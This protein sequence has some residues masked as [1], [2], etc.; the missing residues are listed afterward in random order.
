VEGRP[1]P[2][3]PI[4]RDEVYRISAE[5]LRN[6]FRHSQSRQ[7]VLEIRYDN[8]LLR[9]RIRDD[10]TGIDPNV[11]AHGGREG[12]FGL[13]GMRERAKVIGAKLEVWSENRAGTEVEL[14]VPASKAYLQRTDSGD[15]NSSESFSRK[16]TVVGS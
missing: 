14:S 6:A 10:G 4:L 3:H 5:A 9:V 15:T 8:R 13:H 16:D 7:I 11:L 2:L 12:H 1:R